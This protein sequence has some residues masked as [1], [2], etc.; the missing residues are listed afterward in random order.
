MKISGMQFKNFQQKNKV[1]RVHIIFSKIK[2]D[3]IILKLIIL[4]PGIPNGFQM[5]LAYPQNSKNYRIKVFS[6]ILTNII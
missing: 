4:I 3:L 1:N 2:Q 6:L 5:T